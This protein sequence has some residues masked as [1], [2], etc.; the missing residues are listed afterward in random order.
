MAVPAGPNGDGLI[1]SGLGETGATGIL[2]QEI[3][4][5]ETTR[6]TVMVSAWLNALEF[7]IGGIESVPG[8][9]AVVVFSEGFELMKNRISG[10][11]VWHGFVRLMNRANKSGVVVYSVDPRGLAT[12]GL[13]AEDDGQIPMDDAGDP[14][15][16]KQRDACSMT[17][18]ATT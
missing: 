4:S 9:K 13:T 5:M 6:N 15:G 18:V 14:K 12:T 1:Q 10:E 11:Q 8:R 16:S 3:P 2:S 17:F 7:V